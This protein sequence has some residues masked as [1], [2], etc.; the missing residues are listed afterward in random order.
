MYLTELRMLR[1]VIFDFDGVI[2]DSEPAHYEMFRRVLKEKK[3]DLSWE[4]YCQKYLGYDDYE[5]V[6]NILKDY[7]H[8]P[9]SAL[10][11][12]LV[13]GKQ[14]NFAEYIQNNCLIL[15]GIKEL[16]EDL[17]QNQIICSIH[18]GAI[19]SEVE[20][21][22]EQARL[23]NHF[24]EIVTA[25]DVT[26]SKPHPEGYCLCLSKV[27]HR[28]PFGAPIQPQQCIAIEDSIWGILSAKAAG[29]FCL[30]T[31]TSYPAE[32]L[33]EA[34]KIVRDLTNIRT[35]QLQQMLNHS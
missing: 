31:E 21:I 18:S 4:Q 29:M 34:D 26:H 32:Q 19:R 14:K 8:S 6:E 16:L 12:E 1:M 27:N 20:S 33:T 23:R 13:Q 35:R 11:N 9:L 15:P 7:G 2:A 3:I 10:I 25:D 30:A 5:C 24:E 28:L 22:L 17:R